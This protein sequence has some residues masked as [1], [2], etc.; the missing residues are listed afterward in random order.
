MCFLT[1]S[2]LHSLH[3]C[4]HSYLPVYLY[5]QLMLLCSCIQ[6]AETEPRLAHAAATP[7]L[8]WQYD[9]R[10]YVYQLSEEEPCEDDDEG[11]D[12]VPSYREW[13]ATYESCH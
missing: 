1:V 12:G 7:L 5:R 10:I 4:L 11:E 8:F 13:C 3:S 9:P 6:V 2:C